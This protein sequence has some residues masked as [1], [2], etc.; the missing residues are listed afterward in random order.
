VDVR[1]IDYVIV[2]ELC[3]LVHPDHG[4]AFLKLLA[5]RMPDWAARKD[6]LERQTR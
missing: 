5:E 6:R 3:H 4:A 1:V 2:H